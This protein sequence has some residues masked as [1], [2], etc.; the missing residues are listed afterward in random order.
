MEKGLSEPLPLPITLDVIQFP[1][2]PNEQE[3]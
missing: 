3:T 2:L 1:P